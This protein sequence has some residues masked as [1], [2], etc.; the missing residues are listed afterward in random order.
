[1]TRGIQLF[2]A[3]RPGGAFSHELHG[4][5]V[6]D[7][8]FKVVPHY[9]EPRAWLSQ[10]YNFYEKMSLKSF[11]SKVVDHARFGFAA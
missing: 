10:T 2:S 6:I 8:F 3:R 5:Y 7:Y 4:L 1:M 9:A 11:A